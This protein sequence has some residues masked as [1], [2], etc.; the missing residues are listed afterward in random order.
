[1]NTQDNGGFAYGKV[2]FAVV[3]LGLVGAAVWGA[4]HLM[5]K[6]KEVE[7]STNYWEVKKD[8]FHLTRK[9]TGTLV[10]TDEVMLKSELE[11]HSTIQSVVEEGTKVEGN[12]DYTIKAGDTLKSIAEEYNKDELN[13]KA[14]NKDYKEIDW[15]N[16]EPGQQITLP[17]DLLIELDPL[18]LK[19]RITSQEISVQRQENM[20]NRER[21]NLETMKLSTALALKI[22][23]NNHQLAVLAL[24]RVKNSE[25]K[26]EVFRMSGA[27]T[28]LAND[29]AVNEDKLRWHREL[30][31]KQFVSRMQLREVENNVV[32]LRYQIALQQAMMDA[33]MK[34]EQVTKLSRAELSVDEAVV[35]I[36]RQKVQNKANLS[37]ANSSVLTAQKTLALEIE[38][39]EDLREQMANTRIYAPEPGTVVYYA[40][41]HWE[42]QEPVAD[43]ANV[44]RGQNLIKLPKDKSLKVDISVPQAMRSQL[45]RGMK[46][47][48]QVETGEPVP[49]TLSMISATV[50]TNRRGHTQKSYFKAEVALDSRVELPDSISEGMTVTVEIQVINLIGE[51][52]RIKLP[53]Q[54]VTSRIIGQDI[55]ETGC[56]VLMENGSHQW[57]PV[58]I[59]YNDEN[60]IAIKNEDPEMSGRGLRDGE[61]IHLSPLT[62][63]DELADSLNLEEGVT[64]KGSVPLAKPDPEQMP[65][66]DGEP[67]DMAFTPAQRKKWAAAA[68]QTHED[69]K[70][71]VD[72]V[73]AAK[74]D[75]LQMLT[76]FKNLLDAHRAT[77]KGFLNSEQLKKYDKWIAPQRKLLEGSGAKS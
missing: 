28:N 75:K 10:S 26:T 61:L 59:E 36:E 40:A 15:D 63:A 22:Q 12:F 70:T 29:V 3:A 27:I 54:C 19:E 23:E 35:E 21:G 33:Y 52:Q 77:V 50:D 66:M 43:G 32:K 9:L 30:A 62:Q 11:G 45:R 44:R 68:K 8:D 49:G 13:I 18:Q 42:R 46:A 14:L 64:N 53:N 71:V 17:G 73:H 69:L 20:L 41:K 56:Y 37:D 60:F 55:S 25:I 67:G 72:D 4:R 7:I 24:D 74:I 38:K 1:M 47:W 57:R 34:Y 51:N 39:L 65:R 58:T 5:N 31:A 16:L 48:V 6:E 2:I 76:K